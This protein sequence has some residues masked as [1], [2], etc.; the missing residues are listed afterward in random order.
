MFL[1]QT[2]HVATVE[3][4]IKNHNKVIIVTMEKYSLKTLKG[5]WFNDATLD[6]LRICENI[7]KGVYPC[8]TYKEPDYRS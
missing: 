8:Q 7:S 2:C 1:C 3:N 6:P 4:L 5:H